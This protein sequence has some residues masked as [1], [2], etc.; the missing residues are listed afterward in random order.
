M[1][2]LYLLVATGLFAVSPAKAQQHEIFDPNIASLTVKTGD[3]WRNLPVTSLGGQPVYID[4]DELS[5]DF[6]RY[7]YKIEHCEADWSVSE[8]LF[9]SDFV[10]G[11]AD[12]NT[13]D[14][15]ALSEDTYQLYTHYKLKIPNRQCR[16]TMSGNYRLTVYDDGDE[17]APV[18]SACFMVCDDAAKTALGYT[19]N[20]DIDVN[21]R[22]QQL[23][24]QID[25]GN[26]KITSPERQLYV[27]V[28][29]NRRYDNAVRNP[30]P[31]FRTGTTLKWDHCR[32]LIF[33]A[34][35]E[36][37]K[38]ETLSPSLATMGLEAVG[39]DAELSQWHAYVRPDE[40]ARN[41]VY[42]VDADGAFLIRNS[43][44]NNSDTKCD[45]I[46]TH[47][48]LHA[49]RQNGTVYVSGDWT[50]GQLAPEYEMTWDETDNVYRGVMA[51]KQGYYSYRYA[52]LRPDGTLGSLSADNDFFQT[53]N[54]YQALVYYRGDGDRTYRLVGYAGITTGN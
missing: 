35:S 16:L 6:H 40:P 3:D 36:Y 17:D 22:H 15:Y 51:L 31:T 32:E 21:A 53:E 5:H 12:D 19:T 54:S 47:L 7:T 18:L 11:F 42:D 41:Y 37:Y 25:Y 27:V 1:K 10:Q 29:Q 20:T 46:I 33:P 52:L 34:G 8:E 26:L 49:P 28:L 38:F 30:K 43:D 48:E 39:W 44:Y 14:D 4:F 50:R 24:M 13:I 2:A 45:Y 9:A 23:T